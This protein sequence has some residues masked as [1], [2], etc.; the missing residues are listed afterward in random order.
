MLEAP[1]RVPKGSIILI[2]F[3]FT[4]LSGE[5]LRP[6]LVLY[7][8]YLDVT[9]AAI[10]S[11][12]PQKLLQTDLPI[13]QGMDSFKNTGLKQDSIILIDKIATIEKNV[14]QRHTRRSRCRS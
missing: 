7:E 2:D 6:A 4:D 8:G 5:K 14:Y 9:A 13:L 3:P 10:T 1:P 11:E 12:V